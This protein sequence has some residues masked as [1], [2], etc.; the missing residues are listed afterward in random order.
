[1]L[2][3]KTIVAIVLVAVQVG[4]LVYLGRA[5]KRAAGASLLPTLS[6]KEVEK[7]TITKSG[8][9]VEM[10]R[11]GP[12]AAAAPDG[13]AAPDPTWRIVKPVAYAA[14][15][16][17]VKTLLERLEKMSVSAE[18]IS[19]KT[20]W[21]DEKFGVGDKTGTKIVLIG[22]GG[23]T[24]AELILGK[25]DGGRTFLRKPGED[26]V[27]QATGIMAY[28]FDKKADDWRDK[29]IFDLKDDQIA[30]V[31]IRGAE[32]IVLARDAKDA[33]KWTAESPAGLKL[34]NA[35]AQ[36][37]ARTFAGLRAKEFGT[38]KLD[39]AGLDKPE[40]A[41]V[42]H[43]KD[44]KSHTLLIGKKKGQHDVFVKR[45]DADTIF[46]IGSWQA[47]QLNK[48]V[49]DL[50]EKEPIIAKPAGADVHRIAITTAAGKTS[51][52]RTGPE[53]WR[54]SAPVA[55][56]A[57]TQGVQAIFAEV[58]KMNV[59][60]TTHGGKE[61]H[62]EYE[63]DAKKG[64]RVEL[65]GKD[66]KR[67]TAFVIG[68]EDKGQTY[69]RKVGDDKVYKT[70]GMKRAAFDKPAA[71]WRSKVMLKLAEADVTAVELDKG[72]KGVRVVRDGAGWKLEK[73]TPGA[74]DTQ[75]VKDLVTTLS[76]LWAADFAVAPKP[77][78][79]GL[80]TPALKVSVALKAGK[81]TLLVGKKNAKGESYAQVEGNAQVYLLGS[82]QLG[83][84]D[85]GAADL[86]PSATAV[87]N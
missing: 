12:I 84:I 53:S 61:K 1:M 17:S 59:P 81:K 76:N 3:K 34:D 26:A 51:I 38:E 80:A 69:V 41:V 24:I 78:E 46:V 77:E 32:T 16:A 6:S 14:D 19:K 4:V 13:G 9:T 74:A 35:K 83:R 47:D 48:K 31:E 64:V 66:G 79:T 11:V 60:E 29:I 2:S 28:A 45:A 72:G 23:K 75:K 50:R 44:G 8:T 5:P 56:D 57:D 70:Y 71:A 52:E 15:K 54:M 63:L 27:H 87:K 25:S 18:P 20:D 49:A 65:S 22:A 62:A 68:K 43:T 67:L 55:Q 86:A 58:Q 30:K 73:P 39:A 7:I 82:W 36:S 10:E 85:K 21:H 40:T 42:A 33:V 37:V